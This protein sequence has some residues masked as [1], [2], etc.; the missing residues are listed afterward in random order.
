MAWHTIIRQGSKKA[1]GTSNLPL[2]SPIGRLDSSFFG[3]LGNEKHFP[4]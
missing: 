1:G 2:A 3:F 4:Y